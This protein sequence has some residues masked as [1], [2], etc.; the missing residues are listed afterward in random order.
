MNNFHEMDDEEIYRAQ[1][2]P[3]R[4]IVLFLPPANKKFR[5]IREKVKQNRDF[6]ERAPTEMAS[7]VRKKSC[8]KCANDPGEVICEAFRQWLCMK[9]RLGHRQELS[10]QMDALTLE[11]DQLHRHLTKKIDNEQDLLVRAGH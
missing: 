4:G 5:A 10:Q 3:C 1:V 11:N 8:A 9:H 6:I 7:T 2:L